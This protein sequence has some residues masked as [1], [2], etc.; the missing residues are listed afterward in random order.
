MSKTKRKL[1]VVITLASMIVTSAMPVAAGVVQEARD[2]AASILGYKPTREK[3]TVPNERLEAVE[4][5]VLKTEATGSGGDEEVVYQGSRDSIE[6]QPQDVFT[7]T[8]EQMEHFMQEGFA[9]ADIYEADK[10]ANQ[11]MIP[12]EEL[13]KHKKSE[14]KWEKAVD[15]AKSETAARVVE[16]VYK[17]KYPKEYAE[18][19]KHKLNPE[20]QLQLFAYFDRDDTSSMKDLIVRYQKS[21]EAFKQDQEKIMS[22]SKASALNKLKDAKSTSGKQTTQSAGKNKLTEQDN[23]LMKDLAKKTGKSVEDLTKQYQSF[24]EGAR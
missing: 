7:L 12:P 11:L 23:E 16:R 14:G 5:I 17:T 9:I 15:K 8:A 24:I 2:Q 4:P 20:D 13:L 1:V 22:N 18:I 21:P 3:N 10:L 6:E 19:S